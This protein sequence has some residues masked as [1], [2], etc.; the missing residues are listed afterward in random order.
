MLRLTF[1]GGPVPARR[2]CHAG[3]TGGPMVPM[4][5]RL[6]V[7]TGAGPVTDPVAAMAAHPPAPGHQSPRLS[8]RA[9]D[10]QAAGAPTWL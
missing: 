6:Q 4:V 7:E 2:P 10:P 9:P 8:A 3:A 1:Q 5:A